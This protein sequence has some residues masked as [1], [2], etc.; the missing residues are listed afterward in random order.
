MW[1]P[2]DSDTGAVVVYDLSLGIPVD[3][4]EA[5]SGQ[6]NTGYGSTLAGWGN[7][8]AVGAY[9]ESVPNGSKGVVYLY[10]Y[11]NVPGPS[12]RKYPQ[13]RKP[14]LFRFFPR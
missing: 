12:R 5:P 3:V 14:Y 10:E 13:G 1:G 4:L 11:V 8:I 6:G 7:R 2:I 9:K